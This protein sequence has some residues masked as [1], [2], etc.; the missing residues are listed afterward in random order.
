MVGE[1]SSDEDEKGGRGIVFSKGPC[2]ICPESLT[3]QVDSWYY[4][5]GYQ[6]ITMYYQGEYYDTTMHVG[7]DGVEYNM[8][9]I[10][11]LGNDHNYICLR[12]GVRSIANLSEEDRCAREYINKYVSCSVSPGW[13]DTTEDGMGHFRDG[14][15]EADWVTWLLNEGFFPRTYEGAADAYVWANEL[16]AN[17]TNALPERTASADSNSNVSNM[18]VELEQLTT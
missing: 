8:L 13:Q 3:A 9:E 15:Q 4:Y 18:L 7:A 1:N 5:D 10:D 11:L 14:Q 12:Y 2:T 17:G 16:G 6:P